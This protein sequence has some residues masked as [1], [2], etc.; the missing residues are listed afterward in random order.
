MGRKSLNIPKFDH[1]SLDIKSLPSGICVS[2]LSRPM[3]F[4]KI[5]FCYVQTLTNLVRVIS[6][7]SRL[8]RSAGLCNLGLDPEA[9]RFIK[10]G[11]EYGTSTRVIRGSKKTVVKLGFQ[12]AV[13]DRLGV[14]GG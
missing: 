5:K 2:I 7:L 12:L 9:I 3:S 4:L 10:S 13:V 1:E 8:N 14:D 11:H 6:R